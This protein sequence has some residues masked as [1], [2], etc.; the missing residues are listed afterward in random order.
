MSTIEPFELFCLYH[1]GLD[2]EFSYR[3]RNMHQVA[4]E[5]DLGIMELNQALAEHRMD[6]DTIRHTPYNLAKAHAEASVLVITEQPSSVERFARK[7]YHDY[8][9]ALKRYDP[10]KTF[11][12]VD[13]DNI[14]ED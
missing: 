8:R 2:G 1:L 12:D 6:V 9:E 7:T 3:F 5:L 10:S 13:Y 4:S 11:E 14:W